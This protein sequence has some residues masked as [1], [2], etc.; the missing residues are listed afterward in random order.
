MKGNK[1]WKIKQNKESQRNSSTK[2]F[3]TNTVQIST[4]YSRITR[5]DTVRREM[6]LKDTAGH[7]KV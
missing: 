4:I 3:L 6:H 5:K 1:K 7:A 2:H